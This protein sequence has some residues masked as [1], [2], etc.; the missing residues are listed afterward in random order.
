MVTDGT[1]GLLSRSLPAKSSSYTQSNGLPDSKSPTQRSNSAGNYSN[2]NS[3]NSNPHVYAFENP[4]VAN[5]NTTTNAT[6][7][8]PA[9]NQLPHQQ[10]PYPAA[11]QYSTYTEPTASTTL[12]YTPQETSHAYSNYPANNDAVEAPLLAAFAAQA[13]QV[14]ANGG[15]W[16]RSPN[17]SGTQSSWQQW[18]NTLAGNLEPQDCFSASALVQLGGRVLAEANANSGQGSGMG[19]MN[20]NQAAAMD[21]PTHLGAQVNQ[22]PLN[23]FDIGQGHGTAS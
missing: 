23:I 18:T 8:P 3:N 15:N 11:T 6:Y 12:A 4:P 9:D 13:S 7:P 17:S 19:D 1:L 14:Q 22:W 20:T 21:G 2:S 5:G 10:T 16:Q